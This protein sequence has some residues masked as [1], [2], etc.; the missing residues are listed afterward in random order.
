MF[1][2]ILLVNTKGATLLEKRGVPPINNSMGI[3]HDG[4]GVP[5]PTQLV[6]VGEK[7]FNK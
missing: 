4:V 3:L 5:P 6:L 7:E 1:Y 2:G